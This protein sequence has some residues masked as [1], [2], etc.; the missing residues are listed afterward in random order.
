MKAARKL[1]EP[2][3]A[4][5][6]GERFTQLLRYCRCHRHHRYNINLIQTTEAAHENEPRLCA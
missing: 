1:L 4:L 3:W 2:D 5:D 6:H